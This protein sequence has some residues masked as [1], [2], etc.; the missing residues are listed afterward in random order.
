V[1]FGGGSIIEGL[2]DDTPR[3]T[4]TGVDDSELFWSGHVGVER[5]FNTLGK[6][7]VYGEFYRYDGG[8]ATG[9]PVTAADPLNPT[10]IG[11]WTVWQSDMDMIGAGVAQGFDAASMIVY[12]SYRHVSGNVA[13]RQLQGGSA[14]GPIADAPIDDLDLLLTGAIINF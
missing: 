6:T 4:G 11:T 7:T 1:N 12:L 3:Y 8:T 10:G 2:L 14:S 9:I 5:K 13:L